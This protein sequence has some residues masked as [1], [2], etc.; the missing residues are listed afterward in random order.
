MFP[1]GRPR[2]PSV[3]SRTYV[4]SWTETLQ[5][6]AATRVAFPSRPARPVIVARNDDR[7]WGIIMSGEP[8]SKKEQLLKLLDRGSVFVHL[9][10]RREGV[11]VP[12]WLSHKPQLVLQ[13]GRNF[14]IP[15]PDLEV[16]DLGVSCTLSFN[17][18]PFHCVLPWSAVYALV[19]ENGEVTVWPSELPVELVPE[20]QPVRRNQPNAGGRRAKQQR[21]RISVVPPPDEAGAAEPQIP[22]APS[23]PTSLPPPPVLEDV[24][25][26]VTPA[27]SKGA[28]A[29]ESG[30]IP[31]KPMPDADQSDAQRKAPRERPP[32][33]R[34]VK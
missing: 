11:T 9:D 8:P 31:P 26:R 22:K 10:P 25:A 1:L 21:P 23:R 2:P 12:E 24:S 15:I 13:L 19:A 29:N 27:D 34:L 17:R 32:Y 4:Q 7:E 33:L 20:A 28:R 16:D 18:S 5:A 14:A 30:S 6:A 3:Y